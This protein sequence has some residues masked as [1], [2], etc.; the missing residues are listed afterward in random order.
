MSDYFIK[1]SNGAKNLSNFR[2]LWE[3][4]QKNEYF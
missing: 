3:Y 1:F 2:F 4:M